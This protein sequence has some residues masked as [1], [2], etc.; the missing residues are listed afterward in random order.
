M[1]CNEDVNERVIRELKEEI[2][3]LR[4]Q[5]TQGAGPGDGEGVGGKDAANLQVGALGFRS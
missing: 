5:L 1:K 3:R 2:E 4:Q